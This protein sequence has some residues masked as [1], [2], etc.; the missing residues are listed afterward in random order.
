MTSEDRQA[1]GPD[2]EPARAAGAV[3]RMFL[4]GRPAAGGF[5]LAVTVLGLGLLL[6][7]FG[8]GLTFTAIF[9]NDSFVFFDGIHRLAAGQVP[10]ADF[11]TPAGALSYYLPYLGFRITG[12][13]A[14]AVEAASLILALAVV[15]VS[16][17]ILWGRAGAALSVLLLGVIACVIVVPI[18]PGWTV[19]DYSHAMHYNRWSWGLLLALC[20]LALSP[21][22]ARLP[23]GAVGLLGALLLVAL[24]FVKITYFVFAGL[25]LVALLVYP[26]ARRRSATL[27]LAAAAIMIGLVWLAMPGLVAGYLEDILL[28]L[29]S[30]QAKRGSY[31]DIAQANRQSLMFLALAVYAAL[32]KRD[33][34]WRDHL[35]AALVLASGL[36]ILDQNFQFTFIVTLPAAFAIL[37]TNRGAV[38]EAA[39]L[40]NSVILSA[41]FLMVLPFAQDWAG[42]VLRYASPVEP[43]EFAKLDVAGFDGL[44]VTDRAITHRLTLEKIDVSGMTAGDY[45]VSDLPASALTEREYLA[46]LEDAV[47]LVEAAGARGAPILTLDFTNPVPLLVD[48]PRLPGGVFLDT[49]GPQRQRRHASRWCGDVSGL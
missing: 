14:G 8:R 7:I 34:G 18:V 48:A 11:S 25:F 20:S 23:A 40:A 5:L 6:A 28:A 30:S 39:R 38:T 32:L 31:L 17:L 41:G 19:P 29:R 21:D 37:A 24:F 10:H 45:L 15:P 27:A 12:G 44:H 36:A 2:L 47:R 26:D 33:L 3:R 46:A 22:K 35:L 49:S 9:L 43:G 1:N 42:T 4:A 16:A 13:Y